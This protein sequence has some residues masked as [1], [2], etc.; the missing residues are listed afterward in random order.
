MNRRIF[1]GLALST[2]A[3]T[4]FAAKTRP[5]VR[6]LRLHHLHTEEHLE[7]DYRTGSYY[8]R[9]ALARLNEFLKDFRTGDQT[10]IDPRLFDTLF[11]LQERLDRQ[12]ALYHVVS[13]YR[14]PRTNGM[15]MRTSSGVAKHS[16]HMSGRAIDIRMAETP[17]SVVRSAAIQLAHGGVGYYSKSDFLHLDTGNVRHWGA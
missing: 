14:S 12:G 13:G 9:S 15:L 4:V 7:I 3:T 6:S 16:F 2:S 5:Q 17:T 8:H 10:T 11:D 1:L